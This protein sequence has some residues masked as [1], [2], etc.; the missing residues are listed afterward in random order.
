[1]KP[2]VDP[3]GI[4]DG[5]CEK[6]VMQAL[7]RE[8]NELV[9]RL[10]A[11]GFVKGDLYWDS[12]Q[13]LYDILLYC[14]HSGTDEPLLVGAYVE[15]RIR[16]DL[17]NCLTKRDYSIWLADIWSADP[18]F[19]DIRSWGEPGEH[20]ALSFYAWLGLAAAARVKHLASRRAIIHTANVV[21][22]D[23][24]DPIGGADELDKRSGEIF[25]EEYG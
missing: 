14:H 21:I 23:A 6:L 5:Y 3:S 10:Q 2:L 20:P 4:R 7:M 25:G 8:H 19:A 18:W 13:R 1:M 24:L 9:P 12:Y 22:R 11:I 15:G 17:C 16:D